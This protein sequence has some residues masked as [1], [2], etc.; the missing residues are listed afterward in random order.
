[1]DSLTHGLLAFY[2]LSY[3]GYGYEFLIPVVIGAMFPDLDILFQRISDR[4]PRLFILT[5]GG[6]THSIAGAVVIAIMLTAITTL[7]GY[8]G[9]S[10]PPSGLTLFGAFLAGSLIHIGLDIM[11]FPGIPV[12]YPF[13][14]RKHTLGIF[15]GPSLFIFGVTITFLVLVVL[16]IES[17]QTPSLYLAIVIGFI[18]F[19][20]LIKAVMAGTRQGITIPRMNPLWW[21]IVREDGDVYRLESYRVM[22]QHELLGEFPRYQ[23]ITKEELA[24]YL[25]RPEV[26]RHLYYSYLSVA[27]L[28]DDTLRLYDPLRQEKFI[29]YPRDYVSIKLSLHD[30]PHDDTKPSRD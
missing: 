1:V 8:A 12:L 20:A 17:L 2:L 6:F 10:V 27:I 22:G 16:G 5:H 18:S 11:A 4:N 24:P 23:N 19:R 28:T 14:S 15:P 9:V 29:W 25:D 21:F 3:A 7:I 30:G 26:R 13:S